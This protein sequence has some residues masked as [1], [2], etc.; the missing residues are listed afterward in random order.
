MRRGF[1][2]GRPGTRTAPQDGRTAAAAASA[3]LAR[4]QRLTRNCE[5]PSIGRDSPPIARPLRRRACR[6]QPCRLAVSRHGPT[7]TRHTGASLRGAKFAVFGPECRDSGNP[8]RHP[9]GWRAARRRSAGQASRRAEQA[10]DSRWPQGP[11]APRSRHSARGVGNRAHRLIA[12][13]PDALLIDVPAD[14]AVHPEVSLDDD[15]PL[16]L[17]SRRNEAVPFRLN[18]AMHQPRARFSFRSSRTWD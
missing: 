13:Q 1:P 15:R 6:Q 8:D 3:G 7:Q 2:V 5:E 9:V 11:L 14:L 17:T 10:A 18:P 12:Q 16:S 4:S